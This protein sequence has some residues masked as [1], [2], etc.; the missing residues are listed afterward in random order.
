MNHAPFEGDAG[1]ILR[2]RR[3]LELGMRLFQPHCLEQR[4]RRRAAEAAEAF[5]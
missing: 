2:G 1:D 3:G 5:E 4:H